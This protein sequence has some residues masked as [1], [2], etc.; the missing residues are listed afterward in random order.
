MK[1]SKHCKKS[2][3]DQNDIDAVYLSL[4]LSSPGKDSFVRVLGLLDTGS[5]D[6]AIPASLAVEM[7][8]SALSDDF[9]VDTANGTASAFF[10]EADVRFVCK[11]SGETIVFQNLKVSVTEGLNEVLIGFN[12]IRLFSIHLLGGKPVMF[13]F[14]EKSVQNP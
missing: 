12:F 4:G 11:P 13:E 2:K 10:A 5:S 8:L 9:N 1:H 3:T 7:G 14:D 6:L